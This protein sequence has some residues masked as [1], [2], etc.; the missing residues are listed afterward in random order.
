M[1]SSDSLASLVFILLLPVP[2]FWII[3]HT[4]IGFWRHFV[5]GTYLLLGALYIAVGWAVY[6]ASDWI[7]SYR[8]PINFVTI[9]LGIACLT[10]DAIIW[11][12]IAKDFGGKALIGL[13]EL[14]PEKYPTKLVTT[15]IYARVRHPRYLG[16]LL[17]LLAVFFITG[18]VSLLALFLLLVILFYAVTVVEEREL[19]N[20][21][22]EA[23]RDYQ[24]SVPRLIPRLF[25]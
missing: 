2:L 15:G 3:V 16:Y 21:F 17:L 11:L 12:G 5:K 6:Q 14:M 1:S 13:P 22:G 8:M 23:Y 4:T 20:R 7:G 25:S 19:R 10:G 18:V 9:L 24:K